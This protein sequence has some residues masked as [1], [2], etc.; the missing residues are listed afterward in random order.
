M[1]DL[2]VL[3]CWCVGVRGVVWCRY[4]TAGLGL[5]AWTGLAVQAGATL[6]GGLAAKVVYGAATA[7]KVKA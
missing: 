3:W 6:V 5:D 2:L 4:A 7:P 1:A